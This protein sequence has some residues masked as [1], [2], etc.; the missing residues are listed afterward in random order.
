[1]K[2]R[3][4]LFNERWSLADPLSKAACL[5]RGHKWRELTNTYPGIYGNEAANLADDIRCT[6]ILLTD[7]QDDEQRERF[8]HI[9]S[10]LDKLAGLAKEQWGHIK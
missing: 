10:T 6:A 3:P 9:D 2:E 8:E 7:F 5:L 1:M 4:I